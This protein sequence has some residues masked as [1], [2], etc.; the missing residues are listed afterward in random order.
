MSASCFKLRQA[1]FDNEQAQF[2]NE[3]AQ[4]DNYKLLFRQ[5]FV[6]QLLRGKTTRYSKEINS[7]HFD[8]ESFGELNP[9]RGFKN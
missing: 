4:F 8:V 7:T 3:Q 6:N 2:D 9:L 5:L 1:Q